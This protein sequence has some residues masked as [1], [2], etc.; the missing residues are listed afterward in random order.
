MVRPRG[1]ITKLKLLKRQIYGRAKLDLLRLRFLYS[2]STSGLEHE[3]CV[4][5]SF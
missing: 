2:H 5:A 4:R 3:L 1:K